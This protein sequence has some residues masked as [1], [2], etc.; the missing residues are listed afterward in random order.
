MATDQQL[1]KPAAK[2]T[3]HQ[4][5][6]EFLDTTKSAGAIE[7]NAKEKFREGEETDGVKIV[8]LGINF[9]ENIRNEKET[10][11]PDVVSR[12]YRLRENSGNRPIITELGGEDAVESMLAHL[13]DDLKK[14]GHG[15]NGPLLANGKANIRYIRDEDD[16]LWAVFAVWGAG[17]FGWRVEALSVGDLGKW[18][19]GYQVFSAGVGWR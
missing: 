2:L 1:P 12:I 6:L 10:N 19:A 8:W 17:N 15:E 3:E 9:K 13:W 11:V 18:R 16:C 5:I 14:Q 4:K 7:F